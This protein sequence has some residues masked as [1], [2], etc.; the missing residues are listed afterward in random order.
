MQEV[1]FVGFTQPYHELDQTTE[2]LNELNEMHEGIN[3]NAIILQDGFV[4]CTGSVLIVW[5]E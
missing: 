1:Y 5:C 3:D 4:K 2:R